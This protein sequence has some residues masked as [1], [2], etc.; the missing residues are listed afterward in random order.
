MPVRTREH[1][2]EDES[3]TVLNAAIDQTTWVLRKKIPDYSVDGEIE[4]FDDQGSAT[5]LM[6]LFQLKATDQIDEKKA[7]SYRFSKET[8]AHYCSFDLPVLLV[9]YVSNSH[10]LYYRWASSVDFYYSAKSSESIN[11]IFSKDSVWDSNTPNKLKKYVQAVRRFKQ[12]ILRLPIEFDIEVR[13]DD[14]GGVPAGVIESK[15]RK[16]VEYYSDYFS[17]VDKRDTDGIVP[18]IIVSN[19]NILVDIIG[20]ASTTL[21]YQIS[22]EDSKKPKTEHNIYHSIIIGITIC[23]SNLGHDSIVADIAFKSIFLSGL[24]PET[25]ISMELFFMF[26][27]ANRV[28]LAIKFTD[29]I[30]KLYE[31]S[32]LHNYITCLTPTIGIVPSM[33]ESEKRHYKEV[34]IKSIDKFKEL[35]WLDSLGALHYN[36][37]SWIRANNPMNRLEAMHHYR[38]AAKTNGDYRNRDYFYKEIGGMLFNAGKFRCSEKFYNNALNLGASG[39]CLALRADALMFAGKYKESFTI[40]KEYTMQTDKPKPEWILKKWAI[41]NIIQTTGI[42]EQSRQPK[43]AREVPIPFDG[44]ISEKEKVIKNALELD[45][46]CEGAWFIRGWMLLPENNLVEIMKS[47]LIAAIILPTHIKAW[48]LFF[49]STLFNSKYNELI[50]LSIAYAYENNGESFLLEFSKMVKEHLPETFFPDPVKIEII[51]SISQEIR[52][53]GMK[54]KAQKLFRFHMPGEKYSSKD[55]VNL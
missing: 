4:I 51:N 27:N 38:M 53:Y 44:I 33:K 55:M 11:V 42:F 29:E 9:K 19:D 50:P 45:A 52:T 46:L 47:T 24:L 31:G 40:F 32:F 3:W 30:L 12:P 34:C 22:I 16:I 10:S 7:L 2:L 23:L 15:I 6:F 20:L 18:K 1:I 25:D 21:H 37:A 8:I 49:I 17:F 54:R 13:A 5:G 26:L 41:D 35:G 39:D 28:D 43:L 36:L 48:S 14:L